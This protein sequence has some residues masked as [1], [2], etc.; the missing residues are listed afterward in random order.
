MCVLRLQCVCCGCGRGQASY[1]TCDDLPDWREG[2]EPGDDRVPAAVEGVLRRGEE[3]VES[4]GREDLTR[5]RPPTVIVNSV[6]RCINLF[7]GCV[8]VCVRASKRGL[9]C[10]YVHVF[11]CVHAC[12]R[13]PCG[14][15][16]CVSV[17]VHTSL[18]CLKSA[19]IAASARA[20]LADLIIICATH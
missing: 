7:C 3:R 2:E 1:D 19:R 18:S 5:H 6:K 13:V 17:R 14:E 12:V 4:L 20:P 11:L 16:M 10:A 9:V 8:G 15:W